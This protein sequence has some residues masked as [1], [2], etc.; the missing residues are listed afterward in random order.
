MGCSLKISDY[1]QHLCDDMDRRL[2]EEMREYP[3]ENRVAAN[4]WLYLKAH[5]YVSDRRYEEGLII[6]KQGFP[7]L[8]G[9]IDWW[10][11]VTWGGSDG[12][13]SAVQ[14]SS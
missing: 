2:V 10:G 5:G 12:R 3:F 6:Y 4:K 7:R 11:N 13:S 14:D 1:L 9:H 8:W